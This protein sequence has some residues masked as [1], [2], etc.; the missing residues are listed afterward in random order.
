M[1]IAFIFSFLNHSSKTGINLIVGKFTMTVVE[2]LSH[3]RVFN[4]MDPRMPGLPVLHLPE[5][6]QSHVH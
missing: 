5:L 2:S 1:Y 4:P 3:A 6:A